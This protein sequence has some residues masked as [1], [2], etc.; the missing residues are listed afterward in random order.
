MAVTTS[1]RRRSTKPSTATDQLGALLDRIRSTSELA[2]S[3]RIISL[4][5]L[6][7]ELS[8]ALA[9]C[10]QETA[11]EMLDELTTNGPSRKVGPLT[12]TMAL[13][14]MAEQLGL[15][16][17]AVFTL[18]LAAER[19]AGRPKQAPGRPRRDASTGAPSPDGVT[20]AS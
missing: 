20:I 1:S 6:S 8:A 9:V 5:N 3:K 11:L 7:H 4:G 10:R 14:L 19:R 15:S 16:R 18:V 12:R 13:R 17:T 2:P